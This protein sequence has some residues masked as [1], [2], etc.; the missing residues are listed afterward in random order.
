MQRK[1]PEA[2]SYG[3]FEGSRRIVKPCIGGKESPKQCL[4]INVY[5]GYEKVT[6]LSY[7]IKLP[8]IYFA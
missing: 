5:V 7:P 4:V 8:H 1:S 2:V 6:Y 3:A